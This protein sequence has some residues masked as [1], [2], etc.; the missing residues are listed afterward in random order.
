MNTTGMPPTDAQ[1][2]RRGAL[3]VGFAA[4]LATERPVLGE[5]REYD[6]KVEFMER[7]TRFIDW[8]A[9]AFSSDE[10]PFVLCV[11]GTSPFGPY[12]E[13]LV[14]ERQLKNRAIVLRSIAELAPLDGCHMLFV[15]TSDRKRLK[16]I[17]AKTLR[18]PI[19]TVADSE[20]FARTG[21]LV[22][23]YL[24]EAKHVRFEV[25][26]DAIKLSG[27]KFSSKLLKLARIVASE[28]LP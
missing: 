3:V 10:S 5:T 28:R 8:P 7:F 9:G 22:N 2:L 4:V 24:D 18:R 20:G 15:A 12:L 13:E 21:V 26:A 1:R 23:F 11:A 14:R 16:S 19:L 25:N 17:V 6:V 27:L